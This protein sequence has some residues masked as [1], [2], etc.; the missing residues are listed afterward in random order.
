MFPLFREHSARMPR[1]IHQRHV[2][3]GAIGEYRGEPLYH[4]SLD[5]REYANSYA[6][7]IRNVSHVARMLP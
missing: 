3:W 6:T 2:S 1:I 7:W 5:T 4:G